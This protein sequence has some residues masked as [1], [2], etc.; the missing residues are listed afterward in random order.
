MT[1]QFRNRWCIVTADGHGP[2]WTSA[3]RL[4]NNCRG[5]P[6]PVQYCRL[7]D[8]STL[9]QK[10]LRRAARIA[11]SNQIAVSVL[12]DYREHWEPS[13]WFTS[14]VNRFVS[15]NR[16]VP[17][18]AT[19]A[20]LLSIARESPSSIVTL[21]PARCHV[22]HESTLVAMVEQSI[23]LL[24]LVSEGVITLAMVD[25]HEGID[26]DY[27]ITAR[28]RTGPGFTIQ[29]YAR[30][31]VH[32]VAHH[33]WRQGA[34][35]ASG[36]TV[37]YAGVLAAHLSKHWPGVTDQLSKVTAEALKARVECKVPAELPRG[38]RR[39]MLRTLPWQSPSLPQRALRI[40][41]CGWSSLKS[42]RAVERIIA[43]IEDS[44][45]DHGQIPASHRLQGP[46]RI[47]EMGND[48]RPA[49]P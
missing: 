8:S 1:P 30:Q 35:I 16:A 42:P 29:G 27:L 43:F 13:L 18:L 7:R 48:L 12:G 3:A 20:A 6:L 28:A 45:D 23:A 9:L 32:W 38:V 15:G 34:A 39:P 10:A 49:S 37:G 21:L 11:P 26:E 46:G 44:T 25:M 47:L 24:P 22:E 5:R 40:F 36:V 17:S 19:A 14:P 4:N 2:E 41:R 31:P 33:L